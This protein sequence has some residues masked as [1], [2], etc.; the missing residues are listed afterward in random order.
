MKLEKMKEKV[1]MKNEKAKTKEFNK[2]NVKV[3]YSCVE[4]R[5]FNSALVVQRAPIMS[6]LSIKIRV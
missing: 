1:I 5:Y 3:F 4:Y 2:D 6:P